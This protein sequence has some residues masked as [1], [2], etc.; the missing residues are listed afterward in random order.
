M[1]P[2][3]R[4]DS[5]SHGHNAISYNGTRIALVCM[6]VHVLPYVC[7]CI[8]EAVSAIWFVGTVDIEG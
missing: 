6:Y 1:C 2:M 7:E 5:H 4:T 8:V 3:T